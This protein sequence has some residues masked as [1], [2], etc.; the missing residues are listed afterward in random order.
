VNLLGGCA[1]GG[2]PEGE[3][4]RLVSSRVS[5]SFREDEKRTGAEGLNLKR[6]ERVES[7]LLSAPVPSGAVSGS[8]DI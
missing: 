4:L 2:G 8:G 7:T 1:T 3:M 5:S 6:E